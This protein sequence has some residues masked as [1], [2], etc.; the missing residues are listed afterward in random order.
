[1]FHENAATH[2]GQAD[3]D[4]LHRLFFA[5]QVCLILAVQL[6]TLAMCA[7]VFGPLNHFLPGIF[8]GMS[9]T[10]GMAALLC[11]LS[12]LLSED[13]GSKRLTYLSQS[14][15]VLAALVALGTFLYRAAYVL[16]GLDPNSSLQPEGLLQGPV[17]L[18]TPIAFLL[19]AAAIFL[20]R[21]KQPVASLIADVLISCLAL[22]VLTL[23]S[24]FLFGLAHIPGSSIAGLTSVPSMISLALLTVVA[25]L[26][27]AEFGAFSFLFG[28]GAGSRLSRKLLPVLLVLPFL[29]E[30]GRARLL[31]AQ[32]IP[33]HYATAVLTSMATA[34]SILLLLYVAS[35][36]NKM[37]TAI[38]DLTLRDELTGLY[39]VRGFNLLA[40]Q[41]LRLARRG[42]QEFGVLFIDLD[43]LKLINDEFG[44]S[45]GSASI[46]ETARLL[47]TTFRETD[48]IGRI[49]GDEFVVAGQF[50]H[51]AIL[52]AIDRL[53]DSAAAKHTETGS[54][55]LGFS[56]GYAS[57]QDFPF[58]TI[59][60]L[61]SRA[62]KSM[63]DEKRLKK[64]MAP[65]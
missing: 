51:E 29:R 31:N 52:T 15:A 7:R 40:D 39:N 35:R 9:A 17:V 65:V 46:V 10:A 2:P 12:M 5:Q 21:A 34:A 1:M 54:P 20:A 25:V 18:T 22:L 33:A 47:N 32:L 63:Y 56:T 50:D 13:V 58:E 62:D 60:E 19:L 59:D 42:R 16:G 45:A 37:Q 23:L 49:G 44:H 14:L 36:I 24:E 27:R 41:A 48:V 6:V 4:L 26:R 11:A 53:N 30:L 38:Q 28:Y 43:N 64:M 55:A 61:V 3:P 57:T 8:T